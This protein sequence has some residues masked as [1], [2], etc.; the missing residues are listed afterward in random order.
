MG[1]A[2]VFGSIE[3]S[4]IHSSAM[5]FDIA[6]E[7]AMAT[8]TIHMLSIVTYFLRIFVECVYLAKKNQHTHT[9]P[10]HTHLVAKPKCIL[11]KISIYDIV[12]LKYMYMC[13]YFGVM[14]RFCFA[15]LRFDLL[16]KYSCISQ[17][18]LWNV[19][20]DKRQGPLQTWKL[21]C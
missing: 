7:T 4:Q 1:L 3:C 13:F 2:H 17:R 18:K 10:F 11:F 20:I 5:K 9:H 8:V 6:T 12:S 15:Q 16:G 19:P 21:A 14:L